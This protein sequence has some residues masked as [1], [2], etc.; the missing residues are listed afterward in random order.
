MGNTTV[1]DQALGSRRLQ[2]VP[3]PGDDIKDALSVILAGL[4]LVQLVAT[5]SGATA[6]AGEVRT[7]NKMIW[8]RLGP[9]GRV[10]MSCA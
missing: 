4:G 6:Q 8:L 10:A 2:D 7:R 5:T 9:T 1:G 3:T